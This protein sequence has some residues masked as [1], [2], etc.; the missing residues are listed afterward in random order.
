M[1]GTFWPGQLFIGTADGTLTPNFTYRLCMH[2]MRFFDD[3]SKLSRVPGTCG[4]STLPPPPANLRP[5]LV[6]SFPRKQGKVNAAIYAAC[7]KPA[8]LRLKPHLTTTP[9]PYL[10]TLGVRHRHARFLID[11]M[12]SRS[13]GGIHPSEH[14]AL[15]ETRLFI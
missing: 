10:S 9:V 6:A 2:R 7:D 13:L 15:I 12:A 3:I 5:R 1:Q 8:K 4:R 14:A 11:G